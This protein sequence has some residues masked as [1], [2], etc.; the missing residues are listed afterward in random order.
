[1]GTGSIDANNHK[2]GWNDLRSDYVKHAIILLIEG[3]GGFIR[4][5]S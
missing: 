1:M 5:P 3:C 4:V 2:N